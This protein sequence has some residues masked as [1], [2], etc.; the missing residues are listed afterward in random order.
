MISDIMIV[1]HEM[2]P[3]AFGNFESNLQAIYERGWNSLTKMLLLNP[4]IFATITELRIKF[5]QE[6]KIFSK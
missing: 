6:R 2:W 3:H 5:E 1:V 4:I